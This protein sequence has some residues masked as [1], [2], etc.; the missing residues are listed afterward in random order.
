MF[1]EYEEVSMYICTDGDVLHGGPGMSMGGLAACPA[2]WACS[3]QQVLHILEYQDMVLFRVHIYP[4]VFLHVA[5]MLVCLVS[6][7]DRKS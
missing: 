2:L 4:Y 3:Q 7:I 6:P 1:L 5:G